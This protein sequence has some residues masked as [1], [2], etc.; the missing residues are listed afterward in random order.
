MSSNSATLIPTQQS[1][2]A[3]V[4][5]QVSSAGGTGISFAD[6]EK[7]KFGA[8]NDLQIY[9]DGSNSYVSDVGTG[10]L[11]LKGGGQILLKS[12][13]D[14]NMIIAN[15]NGA[16]SLWYD[17]A[18]KL[19]TTSTG[20]D[21]TGTAT[22]DGFTVEGDATI[23][24]GD[25]TQVSG[26]SGQ[27]YIRHFANSHNDSESAIAFG[28]TTT[29][30]T[31]NEALRIR[32]NGNVGI[33][34]TSPSY[35]LDVASAAANN[36]TLARFSSSGG[37][38]AIFNT[39]S[40]D[41]GSLSLYDK[42]DAAQVLIRSLGSSYLNGGNVGI[43][44][45]SPEGTLHVENASNNAL[46]M[47]APANRYN[48]IGF[49]TAGVDKWWLGRADSDQIAGDAFFIG[50]DNGNVTDAGGLSSK[51]VID[52]SGSVG[53][54]TTSPATTL[55]VAGSGAEIAIR[56]TRN[57]SW[58][59]GDTVASLGFY[60]DDASGSS[61]STLNLARGAIDLVT[62]STFGS[63]HDMVFKTRGDVT[64]SALE[65]L[66]ITSSGRVGIG[67][68][69]PSQALDVVGAIKVSD[70]I[71]NAGAAGSASV[72][73]EDGTTA[74][75]RVESSGNTHMLFVDGGLNRVGIGTS[76]PA[77]TLEISKNDQ[78]NG[79]TLSITN[80]FEGGSWTAG[81]TV[82]T[83]DFRVDDG[84]TTEK[85][86]GQI[87]VF[88]DTS[89]STTYPA[90]NAMS[91][92]TGNLNTLNERM[93]ID[94]SGR[95]GIGT[96][97]PSAKL[98]I[99]TGSDEGIRMQRTGT[100][101][102]FHAIE[103]R[104]SD[105]TAT[106]SKIGWNSNELRLE[107][108]STYRVVT[109][110]SDALLINSLGNVGI[111]TTSPS[112]NLDVTSTV[113]TSIDIQGGDG[114]SKNIIFRKTTGGTQQAKITA[115]GD[116]LRFTTGTTSER[117][118][119]DSSGNVGIGTTSPAFGAISTGI[120]V[121]GTT[122]GIRLQGATTGALELYHNNGLS[123]IDSR[124]ATGGSKLAFN[125]EGSE[126]LRITS[127]GNVG[128]GTSSP[129][130]G[131]QVAKGSSTI[132]AAGASTSS[133]CFGNDASDDN[134][135]VVV[136]ANSNGVGY[137][138]SQ[139]TDGT[140]TTYNLSIQPNG[141]NV[142]IGTSPADKLHVEG[143]IYLGASNR[144]IYTGGSGNLT[145]QTNT[146][147]TIFL[148][149][150]GSSE[151]MRIDSSGNLLVGTTSVQ[152]SGGVTLSGAGYVY[153]SRPSSV[154]IYADR[155]GSDGAIQEFR[156]DGTT[157]GSIATTSGAINLYG[158]SG[159]NGITI[160]SSGNVTA[161]GN[162][163]AYSDERLKDNIQTLQGSKVLEMRGVSYTKDGEASSG[164]IAQEIEKVAPELVHTA[165]DEMGTK[166]VAYGN[167][168]G[169]LIEAIKDQQ[170]EIE[171]M[172]SEIKTLKENK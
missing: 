42:N 16:V 26:A 39:D 131:L 172:K 82:G 104:N 4:D 41:D 19:A 23:K 161:T 113:S 14:E 159:T 50:V 94:S 32:G 165:K 154:A 123:T 140:A 3:Y 101:A 2:K 155:T 129:S 43:G 27:A 73:N 24:G 109:N 31:T 71:L 78:T 47:D 72:F 44:T 116:D 8:G 98:H 64:T 25:N 163:T 22:M 136:G 128:I 13:A 20:I 21:V 149:S 138:S 40:D 38:R 36:Q 147:Q 53:I 112:G 65:R 63:T 69:S 110:S 83:V 81:D 11:I 145:L 77:S 35:T 139:R 122:A 114:N 5:S 93:R 119:I 162:V 148:R 30:G 28:T 157:V 103:F 45:T 61:G 79:A 86:R 76:S 87:K 7:A 160:D 135:G 29:G 170:K 74:D 58:T 150:N 132:P 164:V 106:N 169:Y 125:T 89:V 49:Q 102:N 10:N 18:L 75:F 80:S 9:H 60:S 137:I 54:G 166:S 85:I 1:V 168:V 158:G 33:G 15:G 115:V 62:T 121:E 167:L 95:V 12:P 66:R 99:D 34:T 130:A 124:V 91:F 46:I 105:D 127:S 67:T 68:T 107:A 153:S 37:V 84:S 52:S 144:T 59:I 17:N 156:K 146:G 111:G 120:E 88:D 152:G 151:S 108:T 56:D 126:R 141:G 55:D 6:N 142:G 96:T 48:A 100:N 57:Q 117:M 134:Y 97:S 133:A 118:R 92:S 143:N 70:G 171:Y 90:Y 51:L